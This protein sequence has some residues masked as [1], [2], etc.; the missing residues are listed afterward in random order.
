MERGLDRAV[1]EGQIA[2]RPSFED[3]AEE[4]PV[5]WILSDNW[6]EELPRGGVLTKEYVE[7]KQRSCVVFWVVNYIHKFTIE[8]LTSHLIIS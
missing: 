1:N 6:L 4:R 8:S 3:V 7:S 5:L 2:F